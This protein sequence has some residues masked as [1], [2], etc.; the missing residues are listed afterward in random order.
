[1]SKG[2]LKMAEGYELLAAGLRE[3]ASEEQPAKKEKKV[4]EKDAAQ[5]QPAEPTE[6][7]VTVEMVRAVMADKSREGKTQEVRQLLN[8]FGAD[9]LSA[10]PEE[11]LPALLQKA[12]VL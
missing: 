9:K 10:I 6:K 5:P 12:E 1:M 8:E 7:K 11:K 3:M 4:S 2:L